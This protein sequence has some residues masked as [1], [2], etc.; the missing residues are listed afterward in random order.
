MSY[1][2]SADVRLDQYGA[3]SDREMYGNHPA[4]SPWNPKTWSKKIWAAI[5]VVFLI[6]VVVIPVAVTQT[7][8]HTNNSYPDYSALSYQ[9]SD[10]CQFFL[11]PHL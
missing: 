8:S 9:L 10:T 1:N 3:D 2:K 4:P 6:L 5:I 7:R 11:L